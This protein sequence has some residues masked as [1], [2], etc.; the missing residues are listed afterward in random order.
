MCR[1]SAQVLAPGSSRRVGALDTRFWRTIVSSLNHARDL[2]QNLFQ[3]SYLMAPF[4]L[5]GLSRWT[6]V[7]GDGHLANPST[8]W[9]FR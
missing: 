9:V 1:A 3:E 5:R 6:P 2:D 7:G 4:I 8:A